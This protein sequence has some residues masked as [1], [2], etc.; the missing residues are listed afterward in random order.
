MHPEVAELWSRIE[1]QKAD[2]LA[3]VE[4]MP[5]EKR[6]QKPK[7]GAWSPQEIAEHL[8]KFEEW[9][10]DWIRAAD[11]K[12]ES[13]R[14][15]KG[16]IYTRLMSSLMS[17]PFPSPTVP[18]LEPTGK[19]DLTDIQARWQSVRA[20]WKQHLQTVSGPDTLFAIHPI[21]GP[22]HTRDLLHLADV[23]LQYHLK[24]LAALRS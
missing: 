10:R 9:A 13:K 16:A 8:V 18:E 20:D 7:R 3:Y 14:G 5:S 17:A 21:A 11:T 4:A 19:A 24:Q 15:L 12:P 6:T 2:V 23:H 1:A 22:L